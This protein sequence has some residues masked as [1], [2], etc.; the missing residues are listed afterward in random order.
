MPAA[1]GETSL[2]PAAPRWRAIAVGGLGLAVLAGAAWK[3]LRALRRAALRTRRVT[4]K[5]LFVY[6]I[7]GCRGH[8]VEQAELTKRGLKDDRVYMI[9][10]E[11]WRMVTQRGAPRLAL[12]HPDLPTAEG[13]TLRS[14]SGNSQPPLFVPN[15]ALSLSGQRVQAKCWDDSIPAVDQGDKAA[16]WLRAFLGKDG[17]R[18]VRIDDEAA[19]R[20]CDAAFGVGESA[21]SDGFPILV[22]SQASLEDVAGRV[23]AL[24]IGIE[25][26]RPNVH[27]DGCR[28]WEEDEVRA[29]SFGGAG[30]A[31]PGQAAAATLSLVKP[32]SRCSVPG[33][34]PATAERAE[35]GEPRRTLMAH[36]S[37]RALSR[38][39]AGPHREFFGRSK[40][41]EEVFFG[42]N[43]LPRFEAGA[44][45]AVGD[46][47]V[48]RY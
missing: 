46:V 1:S 35:G 11:Q 24:P 43:A 23:S 12:L 5:S 16:D 39:S 22:S 14:A 20:P 27:V 31:G 2:Q 7:K 30:G 37:G 45:L 6:P 28:A 9:V 34:D 13:I 36:R 48:V 38:S 32:C 10:D 17:L 33:V 26:F 41:L 18:L 25:R 42:Q 44:R 47:G 29:I 15:A 4:I 40:N 21:F 3:A 8:S 19:H